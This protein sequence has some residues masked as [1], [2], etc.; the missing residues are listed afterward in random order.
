[1]RCFAR[2]LLIAALCSAIG[3]H[4]CALQSIAWTAMLVQY[5]KDASLTKAFAQTFDGDHPCSLC[6][7]LQTGKNSEKK[8]DVQTV[9]KLDFFCSR[10]PADAAPAFRRA[11]YTT[12]TDS[13]C[14]RADS[15]LTPPP[16]TALA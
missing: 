13:I 10:R 5:S 9:A 16:R 11:H 3:L 8:A 6:H 2:V 4:W 1:V 7:A 14:T 12:I 15:P